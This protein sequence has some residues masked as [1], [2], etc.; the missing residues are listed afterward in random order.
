METSL[1]AKLILLSAREP[2]LRVLCSPTVFL[3]AHTNTNMFPGSSGFV[4]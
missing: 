2:V 1:E 3:H 4:F